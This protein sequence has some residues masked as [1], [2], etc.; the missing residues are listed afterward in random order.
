[1]TDDLQRTYA[2]MGAVARIANRG[3]LSLRG[4]ALVRILRSSMCYRANKLRALG[5]SHAHH[6]QQ[7]I[8]R[9][10]NPGASGADVRHGASGRTPDNPLRDNTGDAARVEDSDRDPTHELRQYHTASELIRHFA[11]V[12]PAENLAELQAIKEQLE[13]RQPA[14]ELKRTVNEMLRRW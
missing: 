7:D 4:R 1:M 11:D 14:N 12:L 10:A 5:D 9:G 6:E 13:A 8:P 2:R 3:G